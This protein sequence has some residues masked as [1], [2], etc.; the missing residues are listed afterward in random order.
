VGAADHACSLH[1]HVN[2][3]LVVG[4]GPAGVGEGQPLRYEIAL[5]IVNFV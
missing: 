2:C 3:H 1:R 5:S 4:C